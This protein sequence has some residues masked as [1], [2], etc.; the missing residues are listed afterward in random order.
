MSFSV[1]VWK[2][3]DDIML[4]EE[5]TE[6]VSSSYL[7]SSEGSVLMKHNNKT[8]RGNVDSEHAS[9]TKARNRLNQV[10]ADRSTDRPQRARKKKTYS[11]SEEDNEEEQQKKKKKVVSDSEEE[12]LAD[13]R[14]NVNPHLEQSSIQYAATSMLKTSRPLSSLPG[15]SS[16]SPG[17][18]S[19]MRDGS[20]SAI[21]SGKKKSSMSSSS[22]STASR[23]CDFS[24]KQPLLVTTPHTSFS[25]LNRTRDSVDREISDFERNESTPSGIVTPHKSG[26]YVTKAEFYHELQNYVRKED[27]DK[28][29]QR[30]DRL[31]RNVKE[32]IRT[33]EDSD[34]A[35]RIKNFG[36]GNIYDA[37]RELMH[38]AYSEDEILSHTVSG[39][40]ANTKVAVVKPKFTPTRFLK[41]KSAIQGKFPEVAQ[42]PTLLSKKVTAVQKRLFLEKKQRAEKEQP[43]GQQPPLPRI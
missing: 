17:M 6:M 22:S 1:V 8:Y 32:G 40:R 23:Q 14:E 25:S 39:K 43:P 10:N 35:D 31:K 7:I 36:P 34:Y 11:S 37:T 41:L 38:Y 13:N 21:V 18:L 30:Y 15:A 29:R 19:T 28:L 24:L 9:S 20:S 42:D 3:V 5:I 27:H 16:T 12:T 26:E 2:F 33:S 4:E